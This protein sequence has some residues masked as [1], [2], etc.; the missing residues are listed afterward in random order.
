[1]VVV[2]DVK[3]GIMDTVYG[4][5]PPRFVDLVASRIARRSGIAAAARHTGRGS[6]ETPPPR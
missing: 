2:I 4:Q 1:L 3:S 5:P 6:V